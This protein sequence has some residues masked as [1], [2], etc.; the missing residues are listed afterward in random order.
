MYEN[1]TVSFILSSELSERISIIHMNRFASLDH[2]KSQC[3]YMQS[4]KNVSTSTLE[5]RY[6]TRLK[7]AP[8]RLKSKKEKKR[9]SN[10]VCQTYIE[11][12]MLL[13]GLKFDLRLYVLVTA[14][15]PTLRVFLFKDGLVR[16]CTRLKKYSL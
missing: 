12:P 14:V 10:F 11:R 5:H 8:N 7:N 15:K 9:A 2:Y 16:I 13:N 4:T 1:S 3:N 6:K